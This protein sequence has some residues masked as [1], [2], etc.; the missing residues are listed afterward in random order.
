MA[1][2]IPTY[3]MSLFKLPKNL[4]NNINSSL[5]K[6]WWGQNK[7]ER[8]IHWINW[9]RLCNH[10]KK[11]GMGFQDLHAFNL[12][13]FAKQAWR[14]IHHT[15]SLFYRVYKARYFPRCSFLEAELGNNPSLFWRSLLVARDVIKARSQWQVGDGH[16]IGVSTHVWLNQAPRFRNAPPPNLLVC[17]LIDGQTRQWDRGKLFDI[18][19]RQTI[20]DILTIPLTG[21]HTQDCFFWKENRSRTFSVKSAYQVFLHLLLEICMYA[22]E[23]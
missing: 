3:S 9:R 8:K 22:A 21:L 12:A 20:K 5:T 6:Y 1:Q 11:G 13:M 2:A 4:C 19:E 15:R 7:D 10:K 16:T 23:S 14:L 17:D 18:F